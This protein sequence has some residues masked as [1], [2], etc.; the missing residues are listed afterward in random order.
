MKSTSTFIRPSCMI[1][2]VVGLTSLCGLIYGIAAFYKSSSNIDDLRTK[3]SLENSD[4]VMRRALHQVNWSPDLKVRAQRRSQDVLSL[5][6]VFISV[7][8]SK[9]FHQTRLK[10]I[11]DT[12]F[13][14]APNKVRHF[15]ERRIQSKLHQPLTV[16]TSQ[17]SHLLNIT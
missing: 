8:T 3:R 9:K 4:Y 7:K 15:L 10:V 13:N 5:N 2:T 12:W 11:L 1:L 17:S 6:D 14:L 16:I